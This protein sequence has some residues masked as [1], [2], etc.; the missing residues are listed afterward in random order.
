VNLWPTQFIWES[1]AKPFKAFLSKKDEIIG[2]GE[3][4]WDAGHAVHWEAPDEFSALI[5][6]FIEDTK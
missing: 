4:F 1:T 3:E 6:E 5:D 2:C